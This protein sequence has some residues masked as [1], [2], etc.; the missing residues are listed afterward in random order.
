MRI[1]ATAGL[2]LSHYLGSGQQFGSEVHLYAVQTAMVRRPEHGSR[3]GRAQCATCGDWVAFRLRSVA[4]TRRRK[5]LAGASALVSVAVAVLVLT[6]L[7]RSDMQDV[8]PS[9]WAALGLLLV[10][11]CAVLAALTGA[12]LAAAE[13]GCTRVRNQPRDVRSKHMFK[14]PQIRRA[15]RRPGGPDA[16]AHLDVEFD[17]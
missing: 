13:D 6:Y 9:S 2:R 5:Y 7:I 16:T 3:T 11:A 17:D 14:P 10:G 1:E 15:V 12:F 8:G 4:L